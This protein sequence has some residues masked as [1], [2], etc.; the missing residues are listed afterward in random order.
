[1]LFAKPASASSAALSMTSWMMC[2]GESVR[3]YIPGRSR[4]GSRPFSTR[5]E[6]SSYN[7]GYVLQQAGAQCFA[8]DGFG[9]AVPACLAGGGE[10]VQAVGNSLRARTWDV[11]SARWRVQVGAPTWS[12]TTRNSLRSRAR[13]SMVFM[14]LAPCRPYTQ[15]VR[16]IRWRPPAAAIARSPPSLLRP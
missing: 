14:K 11:A 8:K 5:K 7:H 15:L 1:M 13:R 2:I 9:I 12:P 10:M 16:K 3:V 4:T 6:D